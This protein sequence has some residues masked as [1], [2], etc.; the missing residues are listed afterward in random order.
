MKLSAITADRE[1]HVRTSLLMSL[2]GRRRKA[3]LISLGEKPAHYFSFSED[4]RHYN[5]YNI[6]TNQTT[7]IIN[8]TSLLKS[9]NSSLT[10]QTNFTAVFFCLPR[11]CSFCIYC[12]NVSTDTV[13]SKKRVLVTKRMCPF[14]NP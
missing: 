11:T 14:Y 13:I 1:V 12:T 6:I 10:N 3:S 8:N 5:K 2:C 9:C 7:V 4:C